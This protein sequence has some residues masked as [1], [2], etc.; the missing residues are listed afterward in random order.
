VDVR[1]GSN[2][3]GSGNDGPLFYRLYTHT[4]PLVSLPS[5]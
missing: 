5:D 3:R 4:D 2:M 1:I